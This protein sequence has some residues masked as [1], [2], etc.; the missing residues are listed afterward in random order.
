LKFDYKKAFYLRVLEVKKMTD[1][2]ENEIEFLNN[3]KVATVTLSQGRYIS[4]VRKLAGKYPDEVQIVSEN[5]DG[6]IV[7]HI[8]T[9]Y[10]KIS[11]SKRAT[12]E[13]NNA[14]S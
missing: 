13:E 14:F 3:Q 12:S 1:L 6:S 7:A 10:I 4:K 5:Q 9:S 2:R 11:R 8:P